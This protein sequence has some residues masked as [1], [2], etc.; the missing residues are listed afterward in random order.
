VILPEAR[1]RGFEALDGWREGSVRD[2]LAGGGLRET[3]MV[4]VDD[5]GVVSDCD[6]PED[7]PPESPDFPGRGEA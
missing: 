1:V 4:L 3:R 7:L 6:R 2:L 5:Q